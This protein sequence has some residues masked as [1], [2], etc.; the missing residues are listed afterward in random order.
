MLQLLSSFNDNKFKSS[1]GENR[2]HY[3]ASEVFG[4]CLFKQVCSGLFEFYLL[5]NCSTDELG[6]LNELN[7]LPPLTR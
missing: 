2:R 4:F 7:E 3:H 1:W 6:K 5:F